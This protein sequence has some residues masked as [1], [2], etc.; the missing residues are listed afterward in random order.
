MSGFL[1]WV[2]TL[3]YGDEE[4]LVELF[5]DIHFMLFFV[6]ILFLFEAL[7]MVLSSLR[8]CHPASPNSVRC[9]LLRC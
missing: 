6:M 4:H 3:L 1:G 2:S 5:E 8:V 7:I 9:V